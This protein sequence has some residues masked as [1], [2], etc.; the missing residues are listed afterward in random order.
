[1]KEIP[2][3]DQ[4][5]MLKLLAMSQDLSSPAEARIALRRL[6][7]YLKVYDTTR[8]DFISQAQDV[9]IEPKPKKPTGSFQAQPKRAFGKAKV[10]D[11]NTLIQALDQIARGTQN[12]QKVAATALSK[13][14]SKLYGKS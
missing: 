1:M 5:R 11:V 9:S 10:H 6:E 13:Y 14:R 2:P 3:E 8:E 4:K 7:S 12:P